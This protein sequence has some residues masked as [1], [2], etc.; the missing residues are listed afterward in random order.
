MMKQN[1][2]L[3]FYELLRLLDEQGMAQVWL[4]RH[5]TACDYRI[6]K[7]YPPE[8]VQSE[9]GRT[10]FIM[11]GR[12]LSLL[13]HPH[14]VPVHDADVYDDVPYVA[15]SHVVHDD[16]RDSRSLYDLI[17]SPGDRLPPEQV[18]SI[19]IQL[20]DGLAFAH[21]RGVLHRNLKPSNVLFD[22]H[23]NVQ[24]ISF[25][26]GNAIASRIHTGLKAF[27]PHEV[28]E[29]NPWTTQGDVYSIGALGMLMLTGKTP[30]AGV[31]RLPTE[32][33]PELD[34]AWDAILGKCLV[35]EQSGRYD[36]AAQ[37]LAALQAVRPA[38]LQPAPAVI[39]VEEQ[40][41]M[42]ARPVTQQVSKW[43]RWRKELMDLFVLIIFLGIL[44]TILKWWRII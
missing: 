4:A 27:T 29:G 11:D 41:S 39:T 44:W 17:P 8:I 26:V 40:A 30:T 12:Q 28:R 6:V 36:N 2:L 24:L 1:E 32:M 21:S 42:S 22:Q 13:V 25:R 18:A 9:Q 5:R 33:I 34:K 23:G 20:C 7:A 16:G 35:L 38:E 43:E 15:T 3:G 31:M 10:Q 37:V 14:I 19:L